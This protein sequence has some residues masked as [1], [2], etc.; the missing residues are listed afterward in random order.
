VIAPVRWTLAFPFFA[1]PPPPAYPGTVPAAYSPEIIGGI[2]T[3]TP[4]CLWLLGG[5]TSARRKLEPV[6][7]G[8]MCASVAVAALIVFVISFGIPGGT[9]RYEVDFAS[10]IIL[11]AV[12]GWLLFEPS[13]RALQRASTTIG[14]LA[15]LYGAAVGVAI[16]ITGPNDQMATGNPTGYQQ[17]E[18]LTSPLPTLVTMLEGHAR[19]VRVINSLAGYPQNL[20]DYGTYDPTGPEFTAN[21]PPE[22]I[23]VV[24][25]TTGPFI[26]RAS[27]TRT[28][29]APHRGRITVYLKAGGTTAEF[30]FRAGEHA[31]TLPVQRGLN[32]IYLWVTTSKTLPTGTFPAILNVRGLTVAPASGR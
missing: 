6:L 23:D 15:L 16:S 5:F 29:N 13:R 30:N 8:A 32:R 17:L 10:L 25:P 18:D 20:G 27:F 21:V 24:S 28:N 26:V 1:L 2:F 12:I 31:V 9:M 7:L 4:I 11:P 14:A 19:I 3:T 22:E